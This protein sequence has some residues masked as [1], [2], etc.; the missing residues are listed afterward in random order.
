MSFRRTKTQIYI[1]ILRSVQ[2]AGGRLKKTHI[3]Y[4]ANLTHSRLDEYLSF[5]LMQGFLEEE[6][7]SNQIFY[8]ITERGIQFLGKVNKLREIS[9]DIGE[10]IIIRPS[11]F[12]H[13]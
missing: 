9:E 3:V 4:K 13:Y 12:P 7:G 6:R 2:R 10:I 8:A 11:R 1:D 5:L